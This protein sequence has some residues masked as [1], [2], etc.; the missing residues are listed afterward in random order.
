MNSLK[1]KIFIAGHNGMVGKACLKK[2]KS[3]NTYDIIFQDSQKLDL[4]DF[5]SV[6][7]FFSENLKKGIKILL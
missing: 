3:L 7:F 4:R 5:E 6:K 1:E 2:I